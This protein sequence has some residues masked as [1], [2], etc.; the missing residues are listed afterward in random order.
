MAMTM[1]AL[2]AQK[3]NFIPTKLANT[4]IKYGMIDRI[5]RPPLHQVQDT[6]QLLSVISLL[7]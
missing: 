6:V 5:I 7:Y 4:K 2:I 1:I 3:P